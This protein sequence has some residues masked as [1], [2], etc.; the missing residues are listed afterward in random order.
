LLGLHFSPEY[1]GVMFLGNFGWISTTYMASY[2]IIWFSTTVAQHQPIAFVIEAD[3]VTRNAVQSDW[4]SMTK[5]NSANNCP[6]VATATWV[7]Q[8]LRLVLSKGP[9]RVCVS[10]PSPEDGKRCSSRKFVLCN[11]V[12]FLT[13]DKKIP[14]CL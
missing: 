6:W 11:Y 14:N 9:N 7:V 12:H 8:W 3:R 2:R 5:I 1:A 13:M 10:L 4:S